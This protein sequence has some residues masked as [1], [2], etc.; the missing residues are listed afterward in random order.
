MTKHYVA[1]YEIQKKGKVVKSGQVQFAR[2]N[3]SEEHDEDEAFEKAKAAYPTFNIKRETFREVRAA[4]PIPT[5][6]SGNI[7]SRPPVIIPDAG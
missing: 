5:D 6:E 4:G 1:D 2:V 3:V 7:V